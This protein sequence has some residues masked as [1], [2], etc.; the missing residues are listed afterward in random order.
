VSE[1]ARSSLSA[2]PP[3]GF[4][5]GNCLFCDLGLPL[6]RQLLGP[7]DSAHAGGR[8]K[9]RALGFG[10]Q[11]SSFAKAAASFL[12]VKSS[13][14]I[15]IEFVHCLQDLGE[16]AFVLLGHGG[17]IHLAGKMIKGPGRPSS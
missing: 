17:K 4:S 10:N 12:R 14:N 11:I 9:T 15:G 6:R 13:G 1:C 3:L 2:F 16:R 7:G 8:G 5:D